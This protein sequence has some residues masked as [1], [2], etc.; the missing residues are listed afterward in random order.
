MRKSIN[1]NIV[2]ANAFITTGEKILNKEEIVEYVDM[3]RE[4]SNYKTDSFVGGFE[5]NSFARYFDFIFGESRDKRD[6]YILA[7]MD[8]I[9]L[10]KGYFRRR[11]P[12][13]FIR[14]LEETGIEF[15]ENKNKEIQKV[16]VKENK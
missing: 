12:K 10:L 6:L 8:D 4:K 15:K 5:V 11:L 3:V 13:Y 7:E 9:R 2:A 14:I 16:L 1:A